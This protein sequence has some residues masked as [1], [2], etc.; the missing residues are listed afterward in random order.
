MSPELLRHILKQ[1][2]PPEFTIQSYSHRR[3]KM[4]PFFGKTDPDRETRQ[5]W[6]K[7][8]M[9][10]NAGITLADWWRSNMWQNFFSISQILFCICNVFLDLPDS[11]VMIC[12]KTAIWN[13]FYGF[14]NNFRIIEKVIGGSTSFVRIGNSFID[15]SKFLTVI[16][17]KYWDLKHFLGFAKY[18]WIVP[19]WLPG[20]ILIV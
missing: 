12:T 8:G 11:L 15:L 19:F 2:L 1:N 14:A 17:E 13:N 5:G 6:R 16:L 10:E 7:D 20:I 4:P 3:Q 9:V 18:F